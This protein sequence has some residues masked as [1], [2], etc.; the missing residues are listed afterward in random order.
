MSRIAEL[1]EVCDARS[2]SA[3]WSVFSPLYV[4]IM[5]GT[6]TVELR[7]DRHA[8]PHVRV[9]T[10]D[11]T[12]MQEL[13]SVMLATGDMLA[14]REFRSALLVV[15]ERI[16]PDLVAAAR[17]RDEA[18]ESARRIGQYTESGE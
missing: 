16:K 12:R 2:A 18:Y 13:A 15:L 11:E 5:R 3:H 17:K 4:T 6:A 1:V 7:W 14:S 8:V 10:F 9:V